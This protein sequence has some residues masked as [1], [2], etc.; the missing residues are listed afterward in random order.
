[1]TLHDDTHLNSERAAYKA[2]K[3]LVVYLKTIAPVNDHYSHHLLGFAH[4]MGWEI[5]DDQVIGEIIK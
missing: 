2:A 1:M 4:A 3:F 5:V